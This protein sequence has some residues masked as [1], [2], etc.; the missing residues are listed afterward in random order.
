MN[1]TRMMIERVYIEKATELNSDVNEC[2]KDCILR[3]TTIHPYS[4]RQRIRERVFPSDHAT[5]KYDGGTIEYIVWYTFL[6]TK[7]KSTLHNRRIDTNIIYM[8]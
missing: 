6:L 8:K 5:R 4:A 3:Y 2:F 1:A 7:L